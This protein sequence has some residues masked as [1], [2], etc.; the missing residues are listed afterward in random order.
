MVVTRECIPRYYR[1]LKMVWHGGQAS[2]SRK[3]RTMCVASSLIST[4]GGSKSR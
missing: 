1:T 2:G 3:R 4:L